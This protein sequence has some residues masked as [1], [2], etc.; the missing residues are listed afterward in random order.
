MQITESGMYPSVN[1]FDYKTKYFNQHLFRDIET[2]VG[3]A[4]APK[5]EQ[6]V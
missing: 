6:V 2:H 3:E 5:V 1:N 4:V